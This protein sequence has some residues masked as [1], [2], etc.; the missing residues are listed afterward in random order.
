M[1]KRGGITFY[2]LLLLVLVVGF[3]VSANN[4]F[5]VNKF[6]SNLNWTDVNVTVS[7]SP[8]LS[9][10]LGDIVNGMGSAIYNVM[11]W[12][13]QFA[14]DNPTVPWKL[15]IICTIIAILAPIIYYLSQFLI[16]LVILLKEWVV[17]RREKRELEYY[18]NKRK[19]ERL[20][21]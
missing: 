9:N 14:S 7:Q 2:A 10:A 19:Q 3:A 16:V 21:R 18:K 20:S 8:D 13:A 6:K 17:R 4:G 12:V 5:D 11:K 15:L 1:N